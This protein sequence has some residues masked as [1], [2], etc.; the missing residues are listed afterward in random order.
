MHTAIPA[1][2]TFA[3]WGRHAAGLAASTATLLV[4]GACSTSGGTMV[5][6]A[7]A[8]DQ[9]PLPA[10]VQVPAGHRVVLETTTR[11]G[12]ITYECR[13][14]ADMPGQT[15]WV[16]VGP[17]AE[18][19]DRAGAGVGQYFGPPATWR[20]NDGSQFTATQLAV[21]PG[22]EGNLPLQLVKANPAQGAGAWTG[23]THVQRVALK[24]G[25]APASA[26]GLANKGAREVV[27]YQADYIFWKAA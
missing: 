9:S 16:F 25:V 23:V 1:T 12:E 10:A 17:R 19:V 18:L 8:F 3:R 24:G 15:A 4:L 7:K 26:C 14:K 2:A 27:K 13:E 6:A 21:A 11:G 22:G 5:V 20:A